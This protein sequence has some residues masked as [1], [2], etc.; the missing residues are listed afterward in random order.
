LPGAA[1]S[2]HTQDLIVHAV[3]EDSEPVKITISTRFSGETFTRRL[4]I[5]DRALAT[6]LC[7]FLN[8]H[9]GK[10]MAEIGE[11]DASFLG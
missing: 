10:T 2:T 5:Q 4:F 1:I 9:A 3:F 6:V 8:R 11:M 7:E